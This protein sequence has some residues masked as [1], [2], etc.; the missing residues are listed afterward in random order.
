MT[1]V[2]RCTS[3]I[4]MNIEFLSLLEGYK[5]GAEVERRKTEEMNQFELYYIT[6]KSHN[7]TPCIAILNK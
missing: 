3:N 2:E 7:E 4:R 5:K 1:P 6:W